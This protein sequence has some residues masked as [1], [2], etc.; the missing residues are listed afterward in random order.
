MRGWLRV[1][2]LDLRREAR[3]GRLAPTLVALAL[4][5]AALGRTALHD[6]DPATAAA[7][8]LWT[9]AVLVAGLAL[10][11]AYRGEAEAGTLDNLL[12]LPLDR[13]AIVAGKAAS[14]LLLV[15]AAVAAA[16]VLLLATAP[17]PLA[18]AP[19]AAALLVLGVGTV[20]LVTA[21]SLL[22]ALAHRTRAHALLA[23]VLVVPAAFPLVVAGV[24]ATAT[25]LDPGPPH[26]A[27]PEA[28]FMVGYDLALAGLALLLADPALEA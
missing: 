14:H 10:A 7:G 3:R 24:H 18:P 17:L 16:L 25:A 2:A 5:V 8:T 11:R 4:L 19:L 12:V 23:P 22:G 27:A 9:A 20:G 21:A 26:L 28:T 13:A 6:A 15:L 1:A